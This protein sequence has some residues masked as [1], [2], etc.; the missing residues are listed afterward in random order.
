MR[1]GKCVVPLLPPS[2]APFRE[3]KL[4]CN[5]WRHSRTIK[6]QS[7]RGLLTLRSKRVPPKRV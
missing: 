1:N 6:H 4:S 7:S 3:Q 2:F 5:T